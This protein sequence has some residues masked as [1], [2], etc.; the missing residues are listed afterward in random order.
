MV[1]LMAFNDT[2]P[3]A[4]TVPSLLAQESSLN[5][6]WLVEKSKL[7]ENERNVCS[8]GRKILS[9]SKE[10]QG[11]PVLIRVRFDSAQKNI[12]VGPKAASE[13]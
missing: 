1:G 13:K 10:E 5:V 6:C 3:G 9:T 8:M 7:K 12:L 4:P 11:C 2:L